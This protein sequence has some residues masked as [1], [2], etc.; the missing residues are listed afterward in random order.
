MSDRTPD[1]PRPLRD[2]NLLRSAGEHLGTLAEDAKFTYDRYHGQRGA[3][4]AAAKFWDRYAR[5]AKLSKAV[6]E[7]AN[8]G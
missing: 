2:R 6:L 1:L 8:E 4:R 7:I 3:G 5:L